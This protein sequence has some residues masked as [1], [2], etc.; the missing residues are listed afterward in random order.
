M[1]E[2][3]Q[4]LL[5]HGWWRNACKIINSP[6]ITFSQIIYCPGILTWK[7]FNPKYLTHVT[8]VNTASKYRN[9]WSLQTNLS[10][11]LSQF[12]INLSHNPCPGRLDDWNFVIKLNNLKLQNNTWSLQK[13]PACTVKLYLVL[14]TSFVSLLT[15]SP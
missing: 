15:S 5:L 3:V 8:A 13:F 14:V 2:T 11:K 6:P 12:C 10:C 7:V 4:N 9:I 1:N